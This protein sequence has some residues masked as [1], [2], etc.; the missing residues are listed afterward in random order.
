MENL[1]TMIILVLQVIFGSCRKSQGE[2]KDEKCFEKGV[3]YWYIP[4]YKNYIPQG[5]DP[6]YL[7]I[8]YRV[9]QL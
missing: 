9:R 3:N 5:L 2:E 7:F 6:F 4:G 8:D 1:A